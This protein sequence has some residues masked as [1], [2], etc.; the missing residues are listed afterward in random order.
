MFYKRYIQPAINRLHIRVILVSFFGIAGLL[1]GFRFALG[2]VPAL[3][4]LTASFITLR[5]SILMMLAGKL[6]PLVAIWKLLELRGFRLVYV[7]VG[8]T[9][10]IMGYSIGAICVSFA[11]AGWL[12]CCLMLFS[13]LLTAFPLL[14]FTITNIREDKP[15]LRLRIAICATFCVA[16]VL[17]D[18][19]TVSPF[20]SNLFISF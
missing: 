14:W 4:G 7:V 18:Y 19:L 20:V 15:A 2:N 5:T 10:L 11:S 12:V 17:V 8:C 1:S 6:L 16:V 13:Q 3:S 9:M